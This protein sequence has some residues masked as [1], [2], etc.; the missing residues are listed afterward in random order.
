MK[1]GVSKSHRMNNVVADS[2]FFPKITRLESGHGLATLDNHPP[3]KLVV[4]LKQK[5]KNLLDL[6]TATS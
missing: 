2:R 1:Y 5:M 3:N 4:L 6:M